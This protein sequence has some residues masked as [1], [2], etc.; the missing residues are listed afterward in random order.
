MEAKPTGGGGG[1]GNVQ[2]VC[3]VRPINDIERQGAGRVCVECG[4]NGKSIVV[5]SNDPQRAKNPH[6]FTFDRIFDMDATQDAVYE[7][8]AKPIIESV[9][10]GFN[11][12]IFAYG[13]TGS[14]KTHTMLGQVD[15]IDGQGI[16]PRMVRTLFNRIQVASEVMDYSV[17]VS[18]VQIYNENVQDLID[19]RKKKL[20][21]FGEKGKGKGVFIKGAT[22][23]YVTNEAEVF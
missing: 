10:Q 6:T 9:L 20:Q 18:M 4:A 16:I 22:E 17:S 2:V 21:I 13:Q 19:L 3:R 8:T 11:G 5:K 14:G 15:D 23:S 1:S 12:T 7:E